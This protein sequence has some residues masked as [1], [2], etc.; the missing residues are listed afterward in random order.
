MIIN[1]DEQYKYRVPA[2]SEVNSTPRQTNL[3][4]YL[5]TQYQQLPTQIVH[6]VSRMQYHPVKEQNCRET[7]K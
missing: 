1:C 7:E 3:H 5:S 4:T 2:I 6:F